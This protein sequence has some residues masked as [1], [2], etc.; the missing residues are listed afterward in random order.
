MN[1]ERIDFDKLSGYEWS[2]L[3][4]KHPEDRCPWERLFSEDLVPLLEAQPQLANDNCPWQKLAGIDWAHLLSEQPRF[5]N[6]CAWEKLDNEDWQYLL[7]CQPQFAVQSP[8]EELIT[9]S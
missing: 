2:E 4:I 9:G 8:S 1:D 3:L 5:A 7:A 6:R